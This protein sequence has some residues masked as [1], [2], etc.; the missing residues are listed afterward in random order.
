MLKEILKTMLNEKILN[1]KDEKEKEKYAKI[2][3]DLLQKAYAKIGGIKGSGFESPEDMIKKIKLWKIYRKDG[4]IIA[5]LMYKDKG[6]RKRV[7]IFTDGTKEGKQALKIMLRD[8]FERS[9]VEVSGPSLKFIKRNFPDLFEKYKIP[10]KEAE[11]ILKEKLDC[12]DEYFY[13][14]DINGNKLRKILLGT[15]KNFKI[16]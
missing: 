10:C 8:D 4:K 14:R 2:V 9:V 11:K 15:V 3:Y 5:G 1:L 6:F 16:N 7:A 12:E 13:V